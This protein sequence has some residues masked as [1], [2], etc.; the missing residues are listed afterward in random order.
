MESGQLLV[1]LALLLLE[2]GNLLRDD[3]ELILEDSAGSS[4]VRSAA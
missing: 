2:G 4:K 1:N 3:L